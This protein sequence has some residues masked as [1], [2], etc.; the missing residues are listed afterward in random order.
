MINYILIGVI[1]MV[2]GSAIAYII[3]AKRKGQKCIGCPDSKR[4]SGSCASCGCS[5]CHSQQP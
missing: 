4:C 1:V 3:R 2:V 5:A